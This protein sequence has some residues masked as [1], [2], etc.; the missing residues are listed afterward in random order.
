MYSRDEHLGTIWHGTVERI[1]FEKRKEGAR[2]EALRMF[3]NR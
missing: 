2:K 1:V 3:V